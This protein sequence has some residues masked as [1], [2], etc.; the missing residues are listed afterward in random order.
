MKIMLVEDNP[1]DARLTK[2]LLK[3]ITNE[4][5]EIAQ[6]T[7]LSEAVDLLNLSQVDAVLLDLGLP[8][9]NGIETFSKLHASSPQTPI[10]VLSGTTDESVALKTVQLGAQ[11]YL[12]KG[13]LNSNMLHRVIRYAIERK[14]AERE[15]EHSYKRV[16]ALNDLAQTVSQTLELKELLD[17]ALAKVLSIV[18]VEVGFIYLLDNSNKKLVLESQIAPSTI[19]LSEIDRLGLADEEI[20]RMVKWTN[21]LLDLAK[22]LNPSTASSIISPITMAKLNVVSV[23]PLRTKAKMQGILILSSSKTAPLIAEDI[24]LLNGIANQMAVSI[25][26]ASLYRDTKDKAERLSLITSLSRVMCSS[27][28]IRNIYSFFIE[29]IKK[30]ISFDQATITFIAGARVHFF[31]VYSAVQTELASGSTMTASHTGMLWVIENKSTL[32]ENDLEKSRQ[33]AID[34]IYLKDGMKSAISLPLLSHGEIYGTFNLTSRKPYA[35]GKRER[36]VLEEFTVQIAV[37]IENSRL[38]QKIKNLQKNWDT[39]HKEGDTS[40]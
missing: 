6:A 27:L 19:H 8:D 34:E 9:S 32:I 37:A 31:A 28:D 2:E 15:L 4:Q 1:G 39:V 30:L 22:T 11:D 3:E 35:F 20:D 21:P 38:S 29:G 12:V 14:Q 16:R 7:R 18:D 26:N 33:F 13:V 5:F 36:E 10:V 24:E 17:K 23:L 40:F 25:E